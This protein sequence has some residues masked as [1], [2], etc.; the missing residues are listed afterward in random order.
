[1]H[2]NFMKHKFNVIVDFVQ[3][4]FSIFLLTK[5]GISQKNFLIYYVLL[6]GGEE[7]ADRTFLSPAVGMW[8]PNLIVLLIAVYLLI[9]TVRENAPIGI[10]LPTIFKKKKDKA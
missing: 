3:I 4:F 5:K 7:M 1:M 9:H 10:R 2:T 8:S 6:I